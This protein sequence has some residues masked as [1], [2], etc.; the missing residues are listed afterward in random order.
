MLS[1]EQPGALVERWLLHTPAVADVAY[2]KFGWGTQLYC[3]A[4]LY[5]QA[6]LYWQASLYRQK[7]DEKAQDMALDRSLVCRYLEEAGNAFGAT[8]VGRF[9]L[10]GPRPYLEEAG[11]AFGATVVHAMCQDAI[12]HAGVIYELGRGSTQG[13]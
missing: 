1:A 6:P 4:S 7:A 9:G 11:N 10:T 12:E 8:V 3:K 2:T 5:W 13:A